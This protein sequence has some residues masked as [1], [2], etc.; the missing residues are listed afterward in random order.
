M[1]LREM[2]SGVVN[3]TE[4]FIVGNI[5]AADTVIYV[6]DGTSIPYAPNLLV[7]GGNLASAETVKLIEKQGN[8]LTVQRAFQGAANAWTDTTVIARNF[9]E[10]DHSAF[11]HNIKGINSELEAFKDR[12]YSAAVLGVSFLGNSYLGG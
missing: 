11:I 9:T 12:V 8:K 6:Q 2:Y 7:I 1:E 5:S 3:S 10:Y 4:T